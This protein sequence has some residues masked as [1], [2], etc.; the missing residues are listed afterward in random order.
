MTTALTV[1]RANQTVGVLR[2]NQQG[3]IPFTSDSAGWPGD[4]PFPALGRSPFLRRE[5][6]PKRADPSPLSARSAY[7]G[8]AKSGC[9]SRSAARVLAQCRCCLRRHFASRLAGHTARAHQPQVTAS[10]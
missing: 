1:G 5:R 9:S 7:R 8:S 4:F 6:R 3:D 2:I 10:L